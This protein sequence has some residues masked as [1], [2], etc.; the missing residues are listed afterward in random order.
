MISQEAAERG[1]RQVAVRGGR[2]LARRRVIATVAAREAVLRLRAVRGPLMFVQSA[3]CCGGSAPMCLPDGEY[4]TGPGDLLL[5][6]VAGCPF[7]M[8]I[9]QYRALS[10]GQLVLDVEPGMPDGFSLAA[11]EGLHFVTR[12]LPL[13]PEKGTDR[14]GATDRSG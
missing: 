14:T 12:T 6:R 1:G 5:G 3:G 4:I 2:R 9:R 8:D 10:P 11:G 7:Y 13:V